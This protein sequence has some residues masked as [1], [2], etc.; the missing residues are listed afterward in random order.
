MN[1]AET[2]GSVI[3]EELEVKSVLTYY[4][5][6]EIT[7]V[8]LLIKEMSSQGLFLLWQN[9]NKCILF[10]KSCYKITDALA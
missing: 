7:G 9:L 2:D 10:F 1:A 8:S 3:G 6:Q 4:L 5:S